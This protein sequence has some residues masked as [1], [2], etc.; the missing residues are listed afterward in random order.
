MA[1]KP[2]PLSRAGAQVDVSF[3]FFPP[4]TA[5]M[6]GNLWE[7]ATRL[8]PLNPAFVSV[9]YGAGG[10][11][12]ERTHALVQRMARETT[13]KPAAHL[14][15]V[16][17]RCDDIRQTLRDYHSAGVRHIV[18]LRGDPPTGFDAPYEMAPGGYQSTA[19]LVADAREMGFEV[20]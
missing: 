18:A 2:L 12:R 20:S 1:A 15:S 17:A 9:T 13:M 19:E 5:D 3:E 8:E 10:S 11:T 16:R 4:K 6:E 7:A 14:T